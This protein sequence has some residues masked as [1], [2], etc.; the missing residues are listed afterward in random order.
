MTDV[1]PVQRQQLGCIDNKNWRKRI[2]FFK[3]QEAFSRTAPAK[4]ALLIMVVYAH[5]KLVFCFPN[6]RSREPILGAKLLHYGAPHFEPNKED[7]K[8]K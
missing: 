5:G 8:S 7:K 4:P 1:T 3:N 6:G 2:S